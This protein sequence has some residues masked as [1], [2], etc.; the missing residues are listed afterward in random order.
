MFDVGALVFSFSEVLVIEFLREIV[1]LCTLF[2]NS[3]C[4]KLVCGKENFLFCLMLSAESRVP[5][6]IAEVHKTVQ[7]EKHSESEL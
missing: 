1:Q 3:L 6:A 4:Q 7:F 5:S 2:F